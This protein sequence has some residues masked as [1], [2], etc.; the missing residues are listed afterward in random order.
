MAYVKNHN[1]GKITMDLPKANYIYELPL[2]SVGDIHGAVNVSLIFNREMAENDLNPYFIQPGYKLNLQKMIIFSG[3]SPVCVQDAMGNRV[4]VNTESWP[5]TFEDESQRILRQN[6]NTAR[7]YV[8][9]Y[10]D[11]SQEFYNSSG[12]IVLISI[13]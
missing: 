9:E 10:P 6:D 2:L 5:Y 1:P 8:I 13:N 4:N 11:R 3:G 12:M 7:P